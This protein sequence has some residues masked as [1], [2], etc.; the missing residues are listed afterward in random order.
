MVG[1][2]GNGWKGWRG[3]PCAPSSMHST[4]LLMTNCIDKSN[5]R[6]LSYV[7]YAFMSVNDSRTLS[8]LHMIAQHSN[9]PSLP[10]SLPPFPLPTPNTVRDLH[11]A[12]QRLHRRHRQ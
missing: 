8:F 10:P 5:V 1:S 12:A 6:V 3:S 9:P 2:E 11:R 4:S 7:A